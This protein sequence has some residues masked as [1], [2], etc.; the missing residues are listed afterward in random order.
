MYDIL[1]THSG[2]ISEM[3]EGAIFYDIDTTGGQDGSPVYIESDKNKVVAIHKGYCTKNNLNFGTKIT[4][5]VVIL[6]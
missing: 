5:K 6:L 3:T 4:T 2:N 1:L